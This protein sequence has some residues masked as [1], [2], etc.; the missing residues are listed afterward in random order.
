MYAC[1]FDI[2]SIS[3]IGFLVDGY[4]KGVNVILITIGICVFVRK[5]A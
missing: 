2:L 1:Y 5:A 3:S 4:L